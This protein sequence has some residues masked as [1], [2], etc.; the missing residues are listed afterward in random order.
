MISREW[1]GMNRLLR[2]CRMVS[3]ASALLSVSGD[4]DAQ[5]D[6]YTPK[7]RVLEETYGLAISLPATWKET[8]FGAIG[9]PTTI[10]AFIW[11]PPGPTSAMG[12]P[13][14]DI[15]VNE[16]VKEV[17]FRTLCSLHRDLVS[18]QVGKCCAFADIRT[19]R[20]LAELQLASRRFRNPQTGDL[21]ACQHTTAYINE[22][23]VF[24]ASSVIYSE[25]YGYTIDLF[26][27]PSDYPRLAGEFS[28]IVAG[29]KV[30]CERAWCTPDAETKAR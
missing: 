17:P 12:L 1:P 19:G 14:L 4:V 11:H 23:G 10:F 5:Q 7:L 29:I 25:R 28:I 27:Q 16:I 20:R 2:A 21:G 18:A 15:G 9:A 3:L 26:A 8:P 22:T 13:K 30:R 6:K 24:V